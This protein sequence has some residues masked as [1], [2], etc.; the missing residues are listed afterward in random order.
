LLYWLYMKSYF[1]PEFFAGNRTRLRETL[2]ADAPIVITGNGVMQKSGDESSPFSQD[3][4]FWYLTGLNGPDLTLVMHGEHAY[5]IVPGMS[6]VRE[7]F[8]GAHDIKA[9]A[10]RS[11]ITEFVPERQGWQQL[12][13]IVRR[14]K[15]A[16]TLFSPPE[17]MPHYGIYTLPYRRRL[18]ARLRRMSTGIEL[19]DIRTDLALMR[20]VKQPAEMQAIRRA[21][22]ITTETL[23]QVVVSALPGARYEYDLEAALSFGFRSRG[24]NG[25]AFSPVVGAGKHTTTLHHVENNG[26]IASDDLIVLDIG[27]EVEHYAADVA[28]TVSQ[29][30]LTGR[31][32]EVWRAVAAAQDY[33]YGLIKPGVLPL[34][35]EKAVERFIGERLMEI[36]AIQEPT[37]ESIRRH[38]PHMTSHFLGLDTHD[39]GD[40]RAP[41]QAGMVITC[42]P[43]IYLPEEGIGVRLEDDVLITEN[44]CEV[45]SK[46]C[47]RELTP[48]Q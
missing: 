13:E 38:F 10:Q 41:W 21:I 17:H 30:P 43:G 31:K 32:A 16:A 6:D 14:T 5:V 35:Y 25:H 45:L 4:N 15:A 2:H 26:P 46:A 28:R 3:S 24:A 44:G 23:Q 19:R 18:I 39:V 29:T 20:S 7:M 47:P 11:G 1:G 12:R 9:Y 48:V 22:D 37:R 33:A 42:E 40:Y 27:A 34:D 36:G 8:D